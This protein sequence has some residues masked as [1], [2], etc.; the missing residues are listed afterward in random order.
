MMFRSKL[1]GALF[2]A[3]LFPCT[4]LFAPRA[5][6]QDPIRVQSNEVL[7]PTVVF[8]KD[9]YARFKKTRASGRDSYNRLVAQD[10]KLWDA[11][12]AKNLTV[13]DFHLY[14]DGQEQTVQRVKLEPP[15]FRVVQDNLGKHPEIVGTGGGVWAYPDL[16][17][18]EPTVW[19]A[20][21]QYV[22]AYAPPGSP[23]GSC[24]Q[25]QV[26]VERSNLTVW[27][28]GEYC[29][30]P[31]P[32]NDPLEGTELGKKLEKAAASKT[33]NGID[34]KLNVAAFADSV[35]GAR[36]YVTARFPWQ[37]LAH[38]FRDGTLYAS[39]GSQLMVYRKD[40]TLA[41]RYS[42]FAC[43]DYG[44]KKKDSR[45][46]ASTVSDA[47][48]NPGRQL[49]E[50][51]ET[52]FLLSPGEYSIRAVIGDGVHF[53]VRD[54]PLMVASYDSNRL[55][56]SGLAL[57]RRIRKAPTDPAADPVAGNYTPLISKGVEFAPSPTTEFF[58]D[59]TVYVYFEISDPSP[60]AQLD[61][62]VRASLRIVDS[63]SGFVADRFEPVDTATYR[64][65]DRPVI[66]VA[67]G[68]MLNHLSPGAYQLEV[69][70]IDADGK[71]TAWRAA[72]FT[73]IDAPPL[74]LGGATTPA[75][76]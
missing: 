74:E 18:N 48:T 26:K 19:L 58:R 36:V 9:Q 1:P 60:V 41:A 46:D 62:K 40:G 47:P 32:A 25:I 52:Q 43:C 28:R 55:E 37:A 16:P 57:S 17:Q 5:A 2:L 12:M 24:H 73:V 75:T 30:T 35:D 21:P 8:D 68:V 3:F 51:Y 63:R 44:N 76:K 61:G 54:A 66:P 42:D 71:A 65:A 11:I 45:E 7:V 70:A 29:N 4:S 10:A 33:S 14:E 22:L 53:G 13:K 15:G 6:A 34:V 67:R 27:N 56:I 39:I 49:P 50:R 59:E 31:H 23:L 64:K 72:N 38:E 20:W 69:Q